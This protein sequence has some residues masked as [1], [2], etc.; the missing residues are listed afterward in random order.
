MPKSH[1]LQIRLDDATLSLWRDEAERAGLSV[2]EL[3]RESVEARCRLEARLRDE[4]DRQRQA[5]HMQ[6]VALRRLAE[7]EERRGRAPTRDDVLA[8][9]D[10]LQRQ[11]VDG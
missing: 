4:A 5:A 7:V 9:L 3:V 8:K 10:Q 1:V 2:S 6:R 11:L